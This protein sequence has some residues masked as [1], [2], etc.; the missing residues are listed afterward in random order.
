[1]SYSLALWLPLV[2]STPLIIAIQNP[3]DFP[4]SFFSLLSSLALLTFIV[5]LIS[6]I[7]IKWLTFIKRDTINSSMVSLAT[8]ITIQ[9]YIVH[10]FFNYG[11]LDGKKIEWQQF[12]W[13]FWFES[14][15]FVLSIV[16]LTKLYLKIKKHLKTISIGLA[17]FSLLQLIVVLPNY[18]SKKPASNNIQ[19]YDQSVFEFSSNKNIIHILADGFQ[20]DIV[21]QVLDENPDL[22]R[23]FSGFD[24]FENHMG[25]YQG[26][27]PTIPTIFNGRFFDL[28][29][30]YS[31]KTNKQNLDKYSYT[32]VLDKEGYYLDFAP[33]SDTYC[34][35]NAR[36]CD[37]FSFN[38][39]KSRGYKTTTSTLS[40]LLL[41]F[42]ISLF[43]HS[44]MSIKQD[45]YNDGTWLLSTKIK[46][47]ASV[48]FP[49]IK[50]WTNHMQVTTTKPVYKWYHFIG[51]HIP[52]QWDGDCQFHGRLAQ[53]R[54]N[55]LAQT[56][57]V[58]IGLSNLFKKLKAENIYDKTSI[59]IN[60]DHGCNI[61]AN[62]LIG[63]ATNK[64]IFTDSLLGVARPVFMVKKPQS[65][66]QI[67]YYQTKTNLQ[68][69]APTILSIADLNHEDYPG[70]LA[71]KKSSL[72][73][74]RHFQRY[75]AKT[76]WSGEPIE[77]TEFE[78]EGDV[79]NR[80][81]WKLQGI[82][83]TKKAPSSYPY[84]TFDNAYNFTKG[85]SLWKKT[86]KHQESSSILG[87][88]FFVLMSEP[89]KYTSSLEITLKVYQHTQNQTLNTYLNGNKI[90]D[91]IQIKSDDN[92]WTTIVLPIPKDM[93]KK[94]NNLFKFQFSQM[95][96]GESQISISAKI[97]S[98][99]LK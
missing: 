96:H 7:I 32:N 29:K 20:V 22:A 77:Y 87:K 42:D 62:D 35:V 86:G 58:L 65:N 30:G 95:G 92:N 94:E 36:N 39:L 80:S 21:K 3:D 69:I 81:N 70:E 16:V 27:S 57:C 31:H 78:V 54:E 79:R 34:H 4:V 61:S 71:Y 41:L 73:N 47:S 60:G 23:E 49:V 59:I 46:D 74:K 52:A 82:H 53:E 6:Q 10:G 26:T 44:P 15:G 63:E 84:F 37:S 93:M 12:G 8:V 19:S 76:Y 85:M 9:G 66:H 43:R 1:M 83:N 48:P 24:F 56:Q 33:I 55:Y 38:D 11:Q 88:E 90:S 97:K 17:L 89:D 99:V 64:S 13:L 5:I 14:V 18:Q 68:D 50:E 72:S 40:K 51:T 98:I 75:N 67:K 28:N 25:R 2:F 45:I 91:N